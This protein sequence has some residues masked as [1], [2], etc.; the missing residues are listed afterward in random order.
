MGEGRS[1]YKVLIGMPE[2]RRPLGRLRRTWE[3]N[4]KTDLTEIGIDG[5]NWMHLGQNRA[6]WRAFLNTAIN[7]RVL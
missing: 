5:V 7:L 1:V 6:R 2:G 3:V 4:V